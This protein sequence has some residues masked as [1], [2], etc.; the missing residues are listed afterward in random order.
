MLCGW[1]VAAAP[2]H[3]VSRMV[4]E[5]REVDTHTQTHTSVRVPCPF[6]MHHHYMQCVH[7]PLYVPKRRSAGAEPVR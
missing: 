5:V 3:R 4:S 6:C 2:S 7:A 1:P